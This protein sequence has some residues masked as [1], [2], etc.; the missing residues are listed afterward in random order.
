LD[1]PEYVQSVSG[2]ARAKLTGEDW[3]PWV[4]VPAIDLPSVSGKIR[5]LT[6]G[7]FVWGKGAPQIPP[8]RSPEFLSRLV[9]LANFVRSSLTKTA[10]VDLSDIAKQEFGYAPVGMTKGRFAIA[11]KN[12]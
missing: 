12:C 5:E 8:L 2:V 4:Q 3:L 10:Y 7:A 1:G 9:A 11:L 6:Y